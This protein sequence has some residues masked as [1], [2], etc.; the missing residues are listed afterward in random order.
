MFTETTPEQFRLWLEGREDEHLEF[1][2]AKESYHFE[3]LVKY[4]SALANEGGGKMILGVTDK[5]PRVVV[6][7]NA[8]DPLERTKPGLIERLRLRTEAEEFP[9]EGKRVLIFHIPSRPVG[10]PIPY[11]GGYWMRGG[12]GLV[13][14]T[15]DML[16]GIFAET[17]PDYTAEICPEATLDSLDPQAIDRLRQRWHRKSKNEA[18]LGMP[19]EQLLADAELVVD[20]KVTYAALILLGTPAAL[21]RYL[22]QAEVIFEHRSSDASVPAQKRTEYRKGFFLYDDELWETINL[23]NDVQHYQD[24]LF[25]WDIHTFNERVVREALLNAVSHREYRL[26]GSIFIRQYPKRLEIVSPGGFPQGVTPQNILWRQYP[27]NRRIAEVLA[28]C[29]MVERSGQGANIMY[30]ECIKESK[31]L[32]DYIGTDDYQVSLTLKGNVQDIRFLRF[33]EQVGRET[34]VSF[35][36]EDL[37]ILDT[38]RKRE[39]VSKE[40]KPRLEMLREKGLVETVGRGRGTKYLLLKRIYIALGE[41]ATYTRR[42]GLDRETNKALLVRH[43]EYYKEEGS[44]L[45]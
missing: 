24:G 10:W 4:C 15:P 35:T 42:R 11:K 39:V 8:F 2:E 22:P 7:T 26:G 34:Q 31:P 25:I 33:L 30:E 27:R 36:T 41:K 20:R 5:K 1:K 28:K 40:Y 21:S 44:P 16:K 23:Q 45:K 9:W 14:M 13:P 38:L 43:F 32:P 29:G 3:E 37:I 12:D 19:P 6:G 18:L 17:G